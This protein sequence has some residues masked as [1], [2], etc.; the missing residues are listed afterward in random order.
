LSENLSYFF[1][2]N[3]GELLND[4]SAC[5]VIWRRFKFDW[6]ISFGLS[7]F[8]SGKSVWSL[9]TT[10]SALSTARKKFRSNSSSCSSTVSVL[11]DSERVEDVV[12]NV[13]IST[14]TAGITWSVGEYCNMFK[15]LSSWVTSSL[16]LYDILGTSSWFSGWTK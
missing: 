15:S 13:F 14:G 3:K 4:E 1:T 2:V 11:S 9:L 6:S 5:S 12:P 10:P 8:I 7:S 16:S